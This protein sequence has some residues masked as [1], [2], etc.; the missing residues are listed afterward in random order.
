M[1]VVAKNARSCCSF[2][3]NL[4]CNLWSCFFSFLFF[5]YFEKN[6]LTWRNCNCTEFL[7]ILPVLMFDWIEEGFGWCCSDDTWSA[8]AQICG[9]SA[10]ILKNST[11]LWILW[12]LRD[13][14]DYR[15]ITKSRRDLVNLGFASKP[16]EL[17][18][19]LL[20]HRIFVNNFWP[21]RNKNSTTPWNKIA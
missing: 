19:E 21:I 16:S 12:S 2:S 11:L 18:S 14:L 9:R 3:Q 4:W 5:C 20:L 6:Y 10:V 15:K 17:L 1:I 7:L 8:L 13:F